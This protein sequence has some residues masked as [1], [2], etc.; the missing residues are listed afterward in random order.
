MI[1]V[2]FDSDIL[3]SI[4]DIQKN[5]KSLDLVKIPINLSNKFTVQFNYY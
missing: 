4:L 3:N 2:K 5:K 1:K